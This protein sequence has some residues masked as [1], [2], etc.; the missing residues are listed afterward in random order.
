MPRA[1]GPWAMATRS[2]SELLATLHLP[3]PPRR[4][5]VRPAPVTRRRAARV[6][7]AAAASENTARPADVSCEPYPLR[8]FL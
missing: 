6:A 7:P 2:A 5:L 8:T 3:C 4:R 1:K